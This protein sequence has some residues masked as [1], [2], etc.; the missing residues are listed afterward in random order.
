MS[1]LLASSRRCD[2]G[3][4]TTDDFPPGSTDGQVWL[5]DASAGAWVLRVLTAA[6]VGALADDYA[7]AWG[8]VTG[9]PNNYPPESHSHSYTS[10]SSKPFTYGTFWAYS[11]G[12]YSWDFYTFGSGDLHSTTLFIMHL[13]IGSANDYLGMLV[14]ATWDGSSKLSVE[15]AAAPSGYSVSVELGTKLR[16]HKAT[17]DDMTLRVTK[18]QFHQP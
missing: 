12:S 6:D 4:M 8:D 16:L 17:I 15:T 5:W 10:L 7:P 11:P 3:G 18:L 13:R 14:V 9:K 1:L 2:S